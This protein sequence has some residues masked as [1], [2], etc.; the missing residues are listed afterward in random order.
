MDS[1]PR[2]VQKFSVV[3]IAH[4]SNTQVYRSVDEIPADLRKKLVHIE[5][6]SHVDTLVIANEKGRELLQV[7]GWK[8]PEPSR[9]APPLISPALR[10]AVIL[11]LAGAVTIVVNWALRFR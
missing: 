10:W 9:P 2:I 7:E 4:G 6:S 8:K 3:Y 5:R 1:R 11:L